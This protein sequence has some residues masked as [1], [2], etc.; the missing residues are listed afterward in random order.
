MTLAL[1]YELE[2]K[3]EVGGAIAGLAVGTV[4]KNDDPKGL[5]RVRLKLPWR[6]KDFVTD[7]VRI[8]VPMGGREMGTY[9]VP[10]EGDE[11]LVGFDRDD[12]RY[13]YVLGCLWSGTDKPP[14]AN[15][16]KKNDIRMIKSRKGHIVRFDDAAKK[17]VITIQL[18]DGKK[19]EI[20]DDGIRITD[21]KNH[22]EIKSAGGKI[23]IQASQEISMKA[24]KIAIEA[25]KSLDLKGGSALNA[26]AGMVKIN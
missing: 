23:E 7:W 13:P 11:V 19:V 16:N 1:A 21:S 15:S 25:T 3:R 24:P 18:N 17:G 6:E 10:E 22:I 14:E 8:V 26:S 5:G 2:V 4:H 12:I 20:D 9:F